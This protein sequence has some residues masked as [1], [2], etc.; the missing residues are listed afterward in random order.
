MSLLIPGPKAP[1]NDID[2]YLGLLIDELKKLWENGI[3]TFDI[4]TRKKFGLHAAILWTINDFLA[5][6]NL[7]S[8]N[9][10]VYMACPIYNKDA[11]LMYL[12]HGQK[13]CLMWHRRFLPPRHAW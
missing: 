2:V 12:K 7:S 3:D 11:C 1:G 9:T 6:E 13:L 4:V 5:Y 10:K 8:W